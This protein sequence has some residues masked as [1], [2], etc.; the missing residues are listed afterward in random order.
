MI[1]NAL[2]FPTV[3][4]KEDIKN[5]RFLFCLIIS[6]HLELRRYLLWRLDIH[7]LLLEVKLHLILGY[8]TDHRALLGAGLE[9][10]DLI[11]VDLSFS[12]PASRRARHIWCIDS[13]L[14]FCFSPF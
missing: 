5:L 9:G 4:Y 6:C 1:S 14:V 13:S 10:Q 11:S 2:I 12:V 7:L 8:F 3:N